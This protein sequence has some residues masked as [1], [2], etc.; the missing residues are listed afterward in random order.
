[1]PKIEANGI[2]L[3][4]ELHGKESDPVLVINNGILM[5]AA[6]S[7]GLQTG[8][9]SQHCRV[10]LYDCRGQGQ[11]DHPESP[12]SME[13]HAED[14]SCLLDV[15]HIPAAHLLGISYGG[16]VIQAFALRYPE[17]VLS[18]ILADTISELDPQ[19]KLV[20][21]SW[22]RAAQLADPDL[23]FSTTAPWNFSPEYIA[24]HTEILAGARQRYA[25]LDYPAICRL[26]EAFLQVNFTAR[27]GEIKQPV[28]IMVGEK[29]ILKGLSYA[30]LL[31]E[32]IPQAELHILRGAGHASSW[33]VPAEFNSIVLGFLAK[34]G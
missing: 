5:N 6:G 4:Y 31:K 30:R 11:S 2:Q 18:L 19:L 27:L 29:D 14:L 1:M 9:L 13:L 17:R 12:Y 7:W 3:Y 28:C 26:M 32:R 21:E 25:L 15:L 33:E 20:G 22:L 8:V 34:Q 16:E 23:F 10:L 24:A